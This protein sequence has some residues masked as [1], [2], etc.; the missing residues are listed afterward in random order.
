MKKFLLGNLLTFLTVCILVTSCTKEE[1]NPISVKIGFIT[2]NSSSNENEG[3]KSANI[4]LSRASSKDILI[5]YSMSGTAVKGS[6]YSAPTSTTVLIPAGE[7]SGS[8]NY[9]LIDDNEFEANA[10]TI[11]FTLESATEGVLVDSEMSTFTETILGEDSSIVSFKSKI[12]ESSETDEEYSVTI[13]LDKSLKNDATVKFTVSGTASESSDFTFYTSRV[14]HFT[15]G[16]TSSAMHYTIDGDFD[17]EP[18]AETLI[19]TLTEPSTGIVLHS[20]ESETTFTHTILAEQDP[21]VVSFSTS[22]AS[23]NEA[24][25]IVNVTAMLNKISSKDLTVYVDA[26]GLASIQKDYELSSTSIVI[27]A[28]HQSAS[29]ELEIL[30][31]P[32]IEIRNEDIV[33]TLAS[34][35]N[36][37]VIS[38]SSNE[39]I[40]TYTITDNDVASSPDAYNMVIDITWNTGFEATDIDMTLMLESGDVS[41]SIDYATNGSGFETYYFSNNWMNGSYSLTIEHYSG[42]KDVDF[43]VVTTQSDGTRQVFYGTFV[44]GGSADLY[45][46]V[47]IVKDGKLSTISQ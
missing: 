5:Q 3:S 20:S 24:A 45:D 33:L 34:V 1:E 43:T 21:A 40:F 15:A 36:G 29:I 39:K 23:G 11:I 27:P 14:I 8:I 19:V 7:L 6:D 2:V 10:E 4:S 38:N 12:S 26:S 22:T 9:T 16:Q 32:M 42:E 18:H 30:D 31:D 13:H 44:S 47:K 17:Y 41:S 35:N 25:G 37:A 28:G 46:F